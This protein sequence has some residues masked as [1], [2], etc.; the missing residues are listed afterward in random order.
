MLQGSAQA[1]DN[2]VAMGTAQRAVCCRFTQAEIT[3]QQHAEQIREHMEVLA[4]D[5]VH[6]GVVDHMDGP[7]QIKLTKSDPLSEG[8]HHHIPIDWV[9]RVDQHVHLKKDSTEVLAL[10]KRN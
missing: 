4:A 1:D 10:I 8:S 5:G 2:E 9:E 7:S 6:V 3:M